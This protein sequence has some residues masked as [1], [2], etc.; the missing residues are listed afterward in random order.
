[1]LAHT[2]DPVSA[3]DAG[4]LDEVVDS[5]AVVSTAISRAQQFADTLN[6]RAF[7]A[8]REP[9]R[10]IAAARIAATMSADVATFFVDR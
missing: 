6:P 4:F 2:F 8:S 1:M 9:L 3:L 5:D 7:A 10:G